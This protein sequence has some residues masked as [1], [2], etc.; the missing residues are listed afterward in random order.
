MVQS[1]G[2]RSFTRLVLG[3]ATL[4]CTD[5]M[6]QAYP[7]KPIRLIIGFPPG[8]GADAVARPIAE[9]LSKQLGQAVIVDNKPGGGTTIAAT[10]AATAPADGYTLFMHNSSHLGT[11]QA[12]YKQFKHQPS[13]FTPISRWTS[14]PLLLA[15][16][17]NSGIQ[18]V[19]DLIK[20]AKSMPG[21]L[22]YASS[23]VGGGTHLPG[24]L[25]TKAAG[26]DIVHVPYKGGAQA[27]QGVASDE[28]QLTF[29]TPPSA[30]PL[31]KANKLK[32]IAVTSATRSPIFPDLPTVAEGGVRGYEYSFWFGLFGPSGLPAPIVQ[33]LF[34]ASQA[35]LRDPELVNRIVAGGND[36][37]P[38]KSSAEFASWAL[39]D[40]VR[41]TKLA[42]EAGAASG[43]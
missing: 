40:G 42:L 25:F 34:E 16:S 18:N 37:S 4:A 32:I 43:Q 5:T 28:T 20:R 31:A 8:G 24:L 7:S 26:V 23:G 1:F 38:S 3:G 33:K 12:I 14:A 15:V 2:R 13:D 21:K 9:A 19:P 36:V 41:Q 29:A 22:N 30:L 11:L 27:L 6:A 17:I 10:A 39:E 35:V